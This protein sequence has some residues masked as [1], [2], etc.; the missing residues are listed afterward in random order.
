[1]NEIDQ[2]LKQLAVEAQRH[3]PKTKQRQ[4][5]LTKLVRAIQQSGMLIRPR[6]GA[7]QG[8]YG[9]IYAEALQ[10]L[11]FHI[12]ERI[13]DYDPQREVL[14]WANFLLDKRFF[15]EASRTFMPTLP[16][17]VHPK[18]I[19]RL[20]I[21]DLDRNNPIEVKNPETHSLFQEVFQ[22]LES[23]PEGI[24]KSTHISKNPAANFQFLAIKILSGYSWKEISDELG[25]KIPTL[26][27]F[28]QRC[29]TKFIPNF[30]EYLS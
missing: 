18:E 24:F 27:S 2:H 13:D 21:D 29:L 3:P 7:F 10:R 16:K 4:Q 15:V 6:R 17:G 19:T 26:S 20:T 9:E 11:F 30:K 1:M 8:F 12:C 28:Y 23:D 5:A 14:Q 22:Y 25:I